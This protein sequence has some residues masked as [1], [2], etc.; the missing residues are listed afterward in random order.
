MFRD[1]LNFWLPLHF[2]DLLR[3]LFVP[4]EGHVHDPLT[5]H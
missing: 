5:Q 3:D 4:E 1:L 2:Q